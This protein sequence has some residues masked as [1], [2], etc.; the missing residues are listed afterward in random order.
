MEGVLRKDNTE[1]KMEVKVVD[2][3]LKNI[4]TSIEKDMNMMKQNIEDMIKN[5]LLQAQNYLPKEMKN[6]FSGL[7]SSD[8][9][10]E[11]L[12]L[13]QIIERQNKRLVSRM[14]IQMLEREKNW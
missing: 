10:G 3:Q 4:K 6:L 5:Q 14:E 13:E 1:L 2:D 12:S 8:E 9:N 11:A 7:M